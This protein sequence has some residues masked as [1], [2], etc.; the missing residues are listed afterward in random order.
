MEN[1]WRYVRSGEICEITRD[2]SDLILRV[3]KVFRGKYSR[4][5]GT[6]TFD[7]AGDVASLYEFAPE[8]DCV[9][10][11]GLHIANL[12]YDDGAAF[13]TTEKR[14]WHDSYPAVHRIRCSGIRFNM[15][16]SIG[17]TIGN[18]LRKF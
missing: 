17:S 16:L 11:P 13:L 1:Y 8:L 14:D 18:I 6:V 15:Q 4:R 3:Q 9:F 7:G 5:H 12:E 2:G 10:E